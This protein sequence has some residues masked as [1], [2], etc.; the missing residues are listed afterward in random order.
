M[1]ARIA[2]VL[3]VGFPDWRIVQNRKRSGTKKGCLTKA[4][5][6]AQ[7]VKSIRVCRPI[8]FN[9]VCKSAYLSG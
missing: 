7:V 5:C 9:R 4:S 2:G 3:T 1:I 8:T 6:V